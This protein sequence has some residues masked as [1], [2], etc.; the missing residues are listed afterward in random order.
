MNAKQ[1]T[2]PRKLVSKNVLD[3]P[4]AGGTQRTDVAMALGIDSKSI[5]AISGLKLTHPDSQQNFGLYGVAGNPQTT[6]DS[7]GLSVISQNEFESLA[8]VHFPVARL[9]QPI[10]VDL[11]A[12]HP[13]LSNRY[14]SEADLK[15]IYGQVT[16][17]NSHDIRLLE[18]LPGHENAPLTARLT[19]VGL[20]SS[21]YEALSYSWGDSS[22]SSAIMHISTGTSVSTATISPDLADALRTLRYAEKPRTLWIDEI[23]INQADDVERSVQVTQM[24]DIFRHAQNV[25][26][27]LGSESRTSHLAFEL[28]KQSSDFPRFEALIRDPSLVPYFDSFT[29]MMRRPWFRHRWAILEISHAKDAEVYCGSLQARWHQLKQTVALFMVK[30]RDLKHIYRSSTERLLDSLHDVSQLGAHKFV[31][32][33]AET[34]RKSTG[35]DI[36]EYLEP[37]DSLVFKCT[38]LESRDPRDIIYA[39]LGLAS[40]GNLGVQQGI[41]GRHAPL[42][43]PPLNR[44][45]QEAITSEPVGRLER[46]SDRQEVRQTSEF[47]KSALDAIKIDYNK[48][49]FEVCRDFYLHTLEHER[50]LDLL[51]RPWAPNGQG[52]PS[53]MNTVSGTSYVIGK[54]GSYRRA[55]ADPLAGCL[56]PSRIPVYIAARETFPAYQYDAISRPRELG[57]SGFVCGTVSAKRTPAMEGIIPSAWRDLEEWLHITGDCNELLCRTLVADR[58]TASPHSAPPYYTSLWNHILQQI[59]PGSN[60]NTAEF[61]AAEEPDSILDEFLARVQSVIWGRRLLLAAVG[62]QKLLALGPEHTKK[63]DLICILYGCNVPVLLRPVDL[64]RQGPDHPRYRFVGECYVDGLMNGESF[65]LRDKRAIQET[66]FILV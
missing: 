56:G 43:D 30:Y 28:I 21:Q 36:L 60:L 55:H 9:H 64:G 66:S 62:D 40:A 18:L 2:G 13:S 26:I 24:R 41:T 63:R 31:Q 3:A 44:R 49:V 53:W 45:D 61:R 51:C 39:Y 59:A 48:S 27:W 12:R 15:L 10:A 23:C 54:D 4:V 35:G 7:N 6:Y 29:E 5:L 38:W 50:S 25:C 20:G 22:S 47:P 16:L 14:P 11:T 52:L 46:S 42:A 58:G 65:D 8:N 32:L 33:A 34:I 57:L 19:A 37:L 17:P 1:E